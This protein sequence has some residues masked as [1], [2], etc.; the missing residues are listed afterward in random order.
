MRGKEPFG[1]ESLY[2]LLRETV[3]DADWDGEDEVMLSSLDRIMVLSALYERFGVRLPADNLRGEQF[4]TGEE[5]YALCLRSCGGGGRN[6][7]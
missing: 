1:R 4:R 7:S 5:I 2:L 6:G 3:P